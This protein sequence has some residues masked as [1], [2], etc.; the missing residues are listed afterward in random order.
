MCNE[1]LFSQQFDTPF[2]PMATLWV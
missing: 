2:K 1:W